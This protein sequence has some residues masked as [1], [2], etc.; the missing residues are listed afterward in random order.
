MKLYTRS[1][2]RLE[3]IQSVEFRLEKDIQ[4]LIEDNLPELFDLEFV[5]SEF[6]V[7]KFRIDT[8]GFDKE[9]KS[10]VIIEYKKSTS[11]SII[12]QGYTYLSL[13]LNNKSDFIL[14]YIENNDDVIKR[15]EIDWSQSRV[16]FISP[17]FTEY[18]KQSVNFKDI[19][20]DLW[21]IKSFGKN[22]VGLV[23]QQTDSVESVKSLPTDKKNVIK[24]VSREV[25]VYTEDYHLFEKSKKRNQWVVDLYKDL[26]ERIV[27][28]GEIK[29]VPRGDYIGF[30]T[31]RP[32]TDI[33]IYQKGLYIFINMKKGTLND[34]NGETKDVST[35]GHWGN[36]D[37]SILVNEKSDLEYLMF[38][39]KQ[40]FNF[41]INN[42]K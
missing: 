24:K 25:K 33:V 39:I 28:L 26:R 27:N 29:I 15:D 14:E 21:E 37:Y 16:M 20:F 13:M 17:Q 10:F 18:Q 22:L 2:N 19:P 42:K 5:K 8:L 36:G 1:K 6:T 9:K 12:D 38:L 7:K 3:R 4:T 11:F 34:P 30:Q 31:K 41:H 40:S 23:Q 32:F 35:T